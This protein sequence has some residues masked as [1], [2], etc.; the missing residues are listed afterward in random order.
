LAV[1]DDTEKAGKENNVGKAS[2]STTY[3]LFMP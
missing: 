3:L 1:L 2:I